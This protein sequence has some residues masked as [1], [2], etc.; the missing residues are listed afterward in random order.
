MKIPGVLHRSDL[1]LLGIEPQQLS[2]WRH[3]GVLGSAQPWY[4]TAEA[5]ADLI[6]ILRLGVR[7]TCLDAAALHGLWVP[8]RLQRVHVFR[9]RIARGRRTST[10][11][12]GAEVS[13]PQAAP[14]R[15]SGGQIEEKP[16]EEVPL[17]HHSPALRAWP[18]T[19]PVPDLP[20]VLDHAARCLPAID[21]A[22]LFESALEKR[23]SSRSEADQIIAGLPH[24]R[25]HALSRI[26]ADAG[27]GTETTVRWWCESLTVP[28]RAQV[29]IRE[30]G[31]VDL[32]V[33]NS[34]VIEC[35]SRTFHDNPEQYA[36]DRE[37]DLTLRS[38][39]YHVTR[40]TWQQVFV[41]WPETQQMLLTI[42]HRGDHRRMPDK[43]FGRAA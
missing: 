40:L 19:D 38:Y 2:D 42:L 4:F 16:M 8:P 35:D 31:R 23:L 3:Q 27:S 20:L 22:T 34:W 9:P 33:G 1:R 11:Q 25:R 30:V 29:Q 10:R 15:R 39:G 13:A 6:A 41:T 12:G 24:D 21:A 18:D 17:Q 26:R 7:P 14:L 43:P 37:R 32:L 5:P 28:V 36:K